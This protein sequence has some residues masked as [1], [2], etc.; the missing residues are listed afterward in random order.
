MSG[1]SKSWR[2]VREVARTLSVRGNA[3][4]LGRAV[5]LFVCG[6]CVVRHRV[7]VARAEEIEK[8]RQI[9]AAAKRKADEEV[10]ATPL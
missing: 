9:A 10:R 3:Y 4:S 1:E 7:K 8:A 5:L 6:W 2:L